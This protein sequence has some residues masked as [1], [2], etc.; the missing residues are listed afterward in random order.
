MKYNRK[1]GSGDNRC[2]AVALSAHHLLTVCLTIVLLAFALSLT[3]HPLRAT[4]ADMATY[5]RLSEKSTAML[6]KKAGTFLHSPNGQDSALLYYT[7]VA[8]RYNEDGIGD[9]E[10]KECITAMNNAG[11]LYYAF[12]NDYNKAYTT[13]RQALQLVAK[14]GDKYNEA[15][16][17]L[18]MANIKSVFLD[19]QGDQP[20]LARETLQLYRKA[21]YQSVEIRNWPLAVGIFTNMLD[22]NFVGEPSLYSQLRKDISAF[23]RMRIPAGTPLLDFTKA[24]IS[25]VEDIHSHNYA[26]ALA[27]TY[28]MERNIESRDTPKRFAAE[29]LGLRTKIFN[30]MHDDRRAVETMLEG[31]GLCKANHI[32]DGL[33]HF[34]VM[35]SRFFLS[36]GDSAKAQRY[37]LDYLELKEKILTENNLQSVSRL[38]FLYE[39]REANTTVERLTEQKHWLNIIT[40]VI[41][42][43]AIIVSLLLVFIFRSYRRAMRTTRILYR[44]VQDSLHREEEDKTKYKGSR[45]TDDAKELLAQRIDAVMQNTDE[46]CNSDFN[47]DRLA[48]LANSNYKEVS[49]VINEHYGKNF[50]ALLNECR[51]R[52]ACRRLT[53]ANYGHLTIEGVAIS[54]GIKSR[55]HFNSYFKQV[56]GMSPSV[57]QKISKEEEKAD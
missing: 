26:K 13:L 12:Y 6:M 9:A 1:T 40:T 39:L 35:L 14:S 15:M 41:I 38:E 32:D 23:K 36:R 8:N 55:S 49:Q 50:K 29:A 52:E 16:I 25:C 11:Y 34:Y 33:M 45:L 7:I 51:I 5:R 10:R 22:K 20:Q 30:L 54:V 53:D 31:V 27:A 21:F 18:N 24:T 19:V 17:N 3:A 2:V 48:E 28:A 46:I 4:T 37:R 57:Y 44:N 56:T 43:F 42:G 47:L